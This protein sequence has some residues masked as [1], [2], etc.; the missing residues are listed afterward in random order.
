[1]KKNNTTRLLVMALLIAIEI[2]LTR[3][4][5]IN[6]PI[7]RIGFGFLP[8]AMVAILYGPW[9]AGAAYA[10]GDVLGALLF[11]I[12]PPFPGFTISALLTGVIFGVFLYKKPVSWKT[13]LPASLLISLLIDLTLNT[14]WLSILMGKGFLVLLPTR[15]LKAII[16]PPIQILLIPLVYNRIL[17]KIPFEGL[18]N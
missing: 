8:V 2:I 17:S 18:K 15:I 4:L 6:T 11:P 16:M 5:S 13:V 9:F 12:G 10:I 3:F 7:I 14:Y 1:M